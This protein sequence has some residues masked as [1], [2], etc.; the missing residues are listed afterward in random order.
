MKCGDY[1]VKVE[2]GESAITATLNG[3]TVALPQVITASGARYEG[4]LNDVNVAL[5]NKGDD[6]TLY[7]N[8]DAPIDC[9]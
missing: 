7:L 3:D 1:E 9:E 2:I 5:W 4:V 6:W 8:D